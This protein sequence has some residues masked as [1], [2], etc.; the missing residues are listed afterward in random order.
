MVIH[1]TLLAAVHR[2]VLVV[3]TLTDPAPSLASTLSPSGEIEYVHAGSG[4]GVGGPGAGGGGGG[5]GFEACVMS[6]C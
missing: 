6:D 3:D 2:H 5:V 1:A 4:G